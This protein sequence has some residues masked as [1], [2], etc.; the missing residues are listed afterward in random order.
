MRWGGVDANVTEP[1]LGGAVSCVAQPD[2]DIGL[3][4]VGS[5]HTVQLRLIAIEIRHI[6]SR[7]IPA[8]YCCQT[9][10]REGSADH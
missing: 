7:A 2:V 6:R 10:S 4:R 3:V 5:T 8:Y 1:P 9:S